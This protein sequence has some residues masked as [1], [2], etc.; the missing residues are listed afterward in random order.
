MHGDRWAPPRGPRDPI[1]GDWRWTLW[2][3]PR[4]SYQD[5]LERDC[6]QTYRHITGSL[7]SAREASDLSLRELSRT[8]G[9][10]LS[11]LTGLEQGSTWPRVSTVAGVADAVDAT[12]TIE[13]DRDLAAA[14]SRHVPGRLRSGAT[15]ARAAGVRPATL[16]HLAQPGR[17]LSMETVL[18]L[19]IAAGLIWDVRGPA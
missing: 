3:R 4:D 13:G 18:R 8:T 16:Y 15:A 12:V 11:V 14:L 2:G 9:L 5:P 19:S 7:V 10:A 6:V 17:P 1:T